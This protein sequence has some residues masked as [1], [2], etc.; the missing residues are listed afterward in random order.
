VLKCRDFVE[1]A[2]PYLD[3][4]LPL[5]VRLGA[6]HHLWLCEA[7]RNYLEQLRRT[8]R[9]LGSGPPPTPPENESEI[10]A[11]LEAAQRDR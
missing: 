3:G 5:R 2:T 7:C 8:I 10:M 4:A 1:L 9:F 11:L 6:W